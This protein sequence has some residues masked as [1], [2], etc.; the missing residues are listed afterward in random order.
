MKM[1]FEDFGKGTVC[2]TCGGSGKT[3]DHADIGRWVKG[4]RERASKTLRE[5]A[6][7]LNVS[8]SYLSD[9]EHGRRAWNHDLFERVLSA[10][11]S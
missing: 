6:N 2:Q 9:L 11:N 5:V 1:R 4:Y 7:P 8:I 10:I 3:V